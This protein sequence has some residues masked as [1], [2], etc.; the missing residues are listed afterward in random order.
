[1]DRVKRDAVLQNQ[2][3]TTSTVH[4][5]KD[6]LQTCWLCSVHCKKFQI[7]FFSAD[8][9]ACNKIAILENL[10]FYFPQLNIKKMYS[11]ALLMPLIILY[12]SCHKPSVLELWFN[13][14]I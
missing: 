1:M 8:N 4:P 2:N 6:V 14:N 10:C 9:C 12:D 3:K 13:L 7:H 5:S 11:M